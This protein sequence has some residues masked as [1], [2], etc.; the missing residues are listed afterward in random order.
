MRLADE[1]DR[2]AAVSDAAMPVLTSATV[3]EALERTRRGAMTP[4]A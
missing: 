3:R 4:C 2:A 1:S